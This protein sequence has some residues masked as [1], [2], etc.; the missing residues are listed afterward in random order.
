MA[1]FPLP[2][3]PAKKSE[4]E[5]TWAKFAAAVTKEAAAVG[6]RDVHGGWVVEDMEV[7]GKEGMWR[8]W[9]GAMGWEG[10]EAHRAFGE[11]EANGRV[12]PLLGKGPVHETEVYHVELS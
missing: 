5:A 12:G 6:L 10:L 8:A 9:M 4:W 2:L 3:T 11:S 1:Y 7:A